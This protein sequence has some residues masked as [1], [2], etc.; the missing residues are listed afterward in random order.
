MKVYLLSLDGGRCVFYSEGPE[1][2][3]ESE[4][5]V[6]AP[7]RGLRGWV[8]RKFKSL[9]VILTESEKGVGLRVRR[10]WEWL[11]KRTAPDEPLLRGLRGASAVALH[12]APAYTEE[13]A[14]K[15]WH[16]YLKSRRGRHTYW[17]IANVL[18]APLT[19]VFTPLP[20]PNVIGYWVVYRAVCHWLARLGTRNACG[21]A[22]TIQCHTTDALDGA[23]GEND[24]ERIASLTS[25][26]GL[27]G[28]ENFVKRI[29][30]KHARARRKTPLAVS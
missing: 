7:R 11:Q 14:R 12:H 2:A 10:I 19:L 13:E 23:L 27:H 21:D 29:A 5:I 30:A 22:F 16:E 28:L 20:G 17:A 3:A 1:A 15:L 6:P 25:S 24:H 8:E 9:Q 18:T 4:A 26:F